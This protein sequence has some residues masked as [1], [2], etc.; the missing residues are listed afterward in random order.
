MLNVYTNMA[1]TNKMQMVLGY[2]NKIIHH[3]PKKQL[4]SFLSKLSK[5]RVEA[6]NRMRRQLGRVSEG[7]SSHYLA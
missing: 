4:T 5:H 1:A 2:G 3:V 7:Y 6:R